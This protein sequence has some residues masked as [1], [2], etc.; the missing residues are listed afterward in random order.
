MLDNVSLLDNKFLKWPIFRDKKT[1]RETIK[2]DFVLFFK[3]KRTAIN[4]NKVTKMLANKGITKP[5]KGRILSL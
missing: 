5:L 4:N 1:N 2:A 3:I